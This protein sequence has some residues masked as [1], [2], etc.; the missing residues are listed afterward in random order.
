MARSIVALA[1]VPKAYRHYAFER[2]RAL[3]RLSEEEG[4]CRDSTLDSVHA[5]H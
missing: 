3:S 2:E 1:S 5:P 4:G